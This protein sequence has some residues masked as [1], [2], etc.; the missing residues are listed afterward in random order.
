[1]QIVPP[2]RGE[3]G[4][5]GN[6]VNLSVSVSNIRTMPSVSSVIPRFPVRRS[7]EEAVCTD[8]LTFLGGQIE[9]G[10]LAGSGI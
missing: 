5:I 1:M 3:L 4:G 6:L 9:I 2:A 8:G 7:C 10:D